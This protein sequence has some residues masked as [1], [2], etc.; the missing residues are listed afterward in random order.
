VISESRLWIKLAGKGFILNGIK[1]ILGMIN[2]EREPVVQNL[3]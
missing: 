3:D 2:F 1:I